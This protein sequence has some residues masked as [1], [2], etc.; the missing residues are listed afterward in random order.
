MLKQL[1]ALLLAVTL[2]GTPN[3]ADVPLGTEIAVIEMPSITDTSLI[4]RLEGLA[5]EYFE[6]SEAVG[7]SI[8]IVQEGKVHF[9]NRGTVEKD[10]AEVTEH[11]IFRM[12]SISK[13]FTGVILADLVNQ[14]KLSLDDPLQK[15]FDFPI[16]DYE[17]TEIRLIHLATHTSGL[18]PNAPRWYHNISYDEAMLL[19]YMK[20]AELANKPGAVRDYSNLGSGLLGYVI[21]QVTGKPY[22]TVLMETVC[23]RLGMRNTGVALTDEQMSMFATPYKADGDKAWIYP[24][25]TDVLKACGGIASTAYDMVR[26]MAGS[27]GQIAKD[28]ERLTAAFDVSLDT[29][30]KGNDRAGYYSEKA[31]TRIMGLG[32]DFVWDDWWD[33]AYGHSGTSHGFM[34]LA[35]ISP[36]IDA[37]IIIFINNAIDPVQRQTFSYHFMNAIKN[38]K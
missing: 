3:P 16:A 22:D 28:D 13:T 35:V 14:G 15:Y 26:Y 34:S 25:E 20:I 12:G 4:N 8:G 1:C 5:D 18:P 17:G 30:W 11:T 38:T 27:M 32:W 7:M 37:G 2:G 33:G 9:I 29:H 23:G 10:G 21:E 6:N 19:D 36:E 24:W 31:N